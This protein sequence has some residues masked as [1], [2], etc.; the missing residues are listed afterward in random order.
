[1]RF[2]ILGPVRAWRDGHEVHLG[3]PQHRALLGL[4]LVAGGRPVAMAELIDVLWG[5]EPPDSA[6]NG[7]HRIVGILRRVLEPDLAPR[8]TGRW[9]GRS[10]GGYRM[11]V[12]A[13]HLD[14]LRFR[15]LIN[16][17]PDIGGYV[18][19]LALWTGPVLA[20]QFR[21][22]PM[23]VAVDREYQQAARQAADLALTA[24]TAGQV[25]GV[26]RQAADRHPLDEA[27]QA[28]VMLLLTAD[29]RQADA[30]EVY[31]QITRRLADELGVDPGA[32]LR[33]AQQQVL[34]QETD[35]ADRPAQLPR[36]LAVFVGRQDELAGVLALYRPPT[37]AS[38]PVVIS[39]IGG[40]AG[41]GKTTLAVHWAHR[42]AHQ[43]PDGQLYLNLRGF[44]P[45][46]R[47]MDP[48]DAL[49]RL[50][51]ALGVPATRIPAGRDAKAALF[52]SRM[53]GRRM[54]MLLDNARDEQQVRDLL[55]SSPGCLVIVTSR[56]SLAGLVASD[57]AVAV[58][59][60]V[61]A[62]PDAR[63]FLTRRL[64]PVRVH[65]ESDAVD[66]IV[67]FC[68]GLPLAL[69]V[70]AAKAVLRPQQPLAEMAAALH[71]AR[72]LDA[73]TSPDV[74]VNARAVFSWSY[75]ALTPVTARLFRLLA[76]HPGPDVTAEAAAS[77]AGL[78]ADRAQAA[79]DELA[80]GSL[81]TEHAPG[82]YQS[83]DLL[84]AY[85]TELL[86]DDEATD[87]R[88]RFFDHYLHSAVAAKL[89]V[90][91]GAVPVPL[92]PPAA[93]VRP[94]VHAGRDAAF[95]WLQAELWVLVGAVEAGFG[96]GIDSHVWKLT[97]STSRMGLHAD[98][99]IRMLTMSLTAAER[100]GDQ[101]VIARMTDGLAITT[102]RA[103]WLDQAETYARRSLEIATGLGDSGAQIRA[104][105]GLCEIYQ[106]TERAHLLIDVAEHA[107]A[108][109]LDSG[110]ADAES[111]A[112]GALAW[113]YAAM[114]EYDKGFAEGAKVLALAEISG[115]FI[116][117]HAALDSIGFGHLC[118]G[119]HATAV[120]YFEESIEVLRN[121]GHRVSDE[122]AV[123]EHLGDAHLAT[124][125]TTAA[126]QAWRRSL[127]IADDLDAWTAHR[128]RAKL[129]ALPTET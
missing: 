119:D 73:L 62:A 3:K 127:T 79:L 66:T 31:R 21:E 54:L 95:A 109:A 16:D 40:M 18:A 48:G 101:R 35:E 114:G 117:R 90:V 52:R 41:I 58:T 76:V 2:E 71:A 105:M 23:V 72:G 69:A 108:L 82:R 87:A 122:A 53:W 61:L 86:A 126:H 28:R 45:S 51:D 5:D 67:A 24:G 121:S 124:G 85:A 99:E 59:L 33:A 125:D 75:A 8:E 91:P 42:V 98:T 6:T 115:N 37:G 74:T 34:Q 88:Q 77:I 68:G 65:R 106:R 104:L 92:D 11:A 78:T 128:V 55:P 32:E 97:W 27:L 47:L 94:R 17:N 83:H 10:A 29:G 118:R 49:V 7:I 81:I 129:A 100:L 14:L 89:L 102:L 15:A 63:A 4:L 1:M 120:R 103:G 57:G 46:E 93:G 107:L 116:D 96:H 110:G 38:T 20:G 50:L 111:L 44:D 9:L 80:H 113:G 30:L 26:L 56:H 13:E 19:A 22:Q 25:L 43:F 112:R 12:T 60:D 84:R 39:A 36:D 70:V 64:G 123:W